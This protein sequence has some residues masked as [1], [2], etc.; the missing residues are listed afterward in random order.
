M[1]RHRS[2][3]PVTARLGRG[4][5]LVEVMV[6]MTLGLIVL[7][8]TVTLFAGTSRSRSDLERSNRLAENAQF[9]LDL[10]GDELRHA[11]FLADLSLAG[12]T[13]QVPDPCATT[14]DGLGF[15]MVPFQVPVAV[16]GYTGADATPPCVPR[17]R[18]GTAMFTIRR[19]AVETT[20]IAAATG[21]Q[22]VQVSK[23]NLDT[24]RLWRYTSDRAELT[25]RNID[26]A[27]VAD[28]R[29]V[30]VRTYYVADCNEC[31]R[32]TIPTLKR[33][34]VDGDQLVETALVEGVENLQLEY[35]FDRDNDGNADVFLPTLSGVAGAPENLWTNVV[36]VRAYVLGRSRDVEHNH[37][38]AD[39]VYD[40][41]QAGSIAGTRD[42]FKR[43][44][45]ATLVRLP[46]IA[47]PREVP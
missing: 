9:A 28:I 26:C 2:P 34:E 13:W 37:V 5:T 40:F 10:V 4:F 30:V 19:L 32:D 6:A 3:H 43:T 8:V 42:A 25:L 41:G 12:A 14:A 20:P 15:S 1:T 47:G 46:N 22:F 18:A 45:L 24:P 33:L 23:C 38:E 16:R 29:R 35:G 31:G 21:A 27:T 44:M 7:G 36:A 39:R 11:G 17:R